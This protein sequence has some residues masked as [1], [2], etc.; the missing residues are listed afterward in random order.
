MRW[1]RPKSRAQ[2]LERELGAHLELEADEQQDSGMTLEEAYAAYRAF[3]NITVTKEEV[4]RMWGWTRWEILIQD[5]RYALRT[6]R[7]SPGFAATA[8]LTLALG[9]G[10]STAVF[11]AVKP[12]T[13]QSGH[14]SS[15]MGESP[16]ENHA[17]EHGAAPPGNRERQNAARA[18]EQKGFR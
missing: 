1:R 16:V 3:G 17:D 5:V 18:G 9:I 10:A 11:T 7:K 2:D 15:G 4:R 13:R 14:T 8:I 6:L 12:K